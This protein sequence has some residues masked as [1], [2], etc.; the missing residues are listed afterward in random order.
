MGRTAS[1]DGGRWVAAR[2]VLLDPAGR[3]VKVEERIALAA[4]LANARAGLEAQAGPRDDPHGGVPDQARSS[5]AKPRWRAAAS[6][7]GSGWSRA[8][9]TQL[10]HPA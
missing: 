10:S 8:E 9:A 6:R 2:D 7:P 4:L 5:P 1:G 3:I